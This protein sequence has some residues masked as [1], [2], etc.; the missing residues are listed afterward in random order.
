[1]LGKRSAKALPQ[2]QCPKNNSAFSLGADKSSDW[3]ECVAANPT[4]V[5]THRCVFSWNNCTPDRIL[6][7]KPTVQYMPLLI[8]IQRV[9][10]GFLQGIC[11]VHFHAYFHG[12]AFFI[13]QRDC[14][15]K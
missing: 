9:E 6:R 3:N 10:A 5:E 2:E 4:Y 14:T 7:D 13:W 12:V 15:H 11:P 8:G 1:M